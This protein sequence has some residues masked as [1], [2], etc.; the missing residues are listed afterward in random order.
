VVAEH[1]EGVRPALGDV[2]N[3]PQRCVGLR[4]LIADDRLCDV[5]GLRGLARDV[6]ARAV[7]AIEVATRLVEDGL[8]FR[9]IPRGVGVFEFH[10]DEGVVVE[11]EFR[12]LEA[13][14]GM[15]LDDEDLVA[16]HCLAIHD[17]GLRALDRVFHEFR[18]IAPA[19]VEGHLDLL[20][21]ARGRREQHEQ[22]QREKRQR[23]SEN[24]HHRV[25]SIR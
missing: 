23:A 15:P 14:V 20:G 6:A 17:A 25:S 16:V 8:D 2:E 10:F 21:R 12:A 19:E 11:G 9:G 3:E 13:R 5:A 24:G 4:P 18:R 7:F 22:Q 1:A